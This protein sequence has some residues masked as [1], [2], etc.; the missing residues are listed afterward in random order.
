MINI[1]KVVSILIVRYL[2][3]K[4]VDSFIHLDAKVYKNTYLVDKKTTLKRLH[5]NPYSDITFI[6]EDGSLM[7]YISLCPVSDSVYSSIKELNISEKETEEN[8]ISYKKHGFYSAYLSSIV[9]DKEKFP[10]LTSKLLF[11]EL[12]KHLI[13]LRKKGFIVSRMVAVAVST[14]GRKTLERFGFTESKTNK[15]IFF[16]HCKTNLPSFFHENKHFCALLS[17]L[18]SLKGIH[19]RSV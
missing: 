5:R 14:A 19:W 18:H 6:H 3:E 13:R 17:L 8:T 12:E 10:Y 9:I 7:G 15:N 11:K 2:Q 1:R 16:F 4:D